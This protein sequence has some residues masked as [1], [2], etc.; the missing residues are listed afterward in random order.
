MSIVHFN[1]GGTRYSTSTTTLTRDPN[2]MLATMLHQ[3]NEINLIHHG[4]EIF[5][6]RN[7]KLFEYVLDYLRDGATDLT[8]PNDKVL[9]EKLLKE[10]DFYQLNE[11]STIIKQKSGDIHVVRQ[12]TFAVGSTVKFNERA[13]NSIVLQDYLDM[14]NHPDYV[15]LKFGPDI[16]GRLTSVPC[17]FCHEPAAQ[18]LRNYDRNSSPGCDKSKYNKYQ[19]ILL[20]TWGQICSRSETCCL[21]KFIYPKFNAPVVLKQVLGI[22]QFERTPTDYIFLHVPILFLEL[23]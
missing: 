7:G 18:K 12:P 15:D 6:D 17:W 4:Q 13:S 2:S 9:L 5:I 1:V 23:L 19:A 16:Q 20:A 3:S 10:A 11:F 22:S 21:V 14:M 8:L